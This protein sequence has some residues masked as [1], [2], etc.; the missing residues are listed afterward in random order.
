MMA[1]TIFS[2]VIQRL[3]AY[4]LFKAGVSNSNFL[5]GQVRTYKYPEDRIMTTQQ[6][7]S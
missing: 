5:E 4:L 1:Q 3:V 6:G 7:R 2:V